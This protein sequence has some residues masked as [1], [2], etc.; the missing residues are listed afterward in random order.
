[1]TARRAA[2]PAPGR[3]NLKVSGC[4]ILCVTVEF[5]LEFADVVLKVV[6]GEQY[7]VASGIIQLI[8]QYHL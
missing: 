7:G 2:W 8:R 5:M 6:P 1:M 4:H 3:L